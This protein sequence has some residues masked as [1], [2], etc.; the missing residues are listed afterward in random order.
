MNARWIRVVL[1]LATVAASVRAQQPSAPSD[2]KAA[3]PASRP[4]APPRIA[5][6]WSTAS[7]VDNHGFFIMRAQS[8][9]GPFVARNER[10]IPGAGMSDVKKEYVFEDTEVVLG[11]TYYYYI[12]AV[13]I[14]GGRWKVSPV[15]SNV[16]CATATATPGSAQPPPP[17]PPG[18]SGRGGPGDESRP[19]PR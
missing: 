13:S 17:T 10:P 16:C 18:A 19:E 1:F 3:V 9:E 12:D 2:A 14:R 5:L 6:K 15:R 4:V 7:E 8:E 11:Q